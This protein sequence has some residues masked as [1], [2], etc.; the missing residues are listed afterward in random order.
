MAGGVPF[1]VLRG[2][3]ERHGWTLCRVRGLNHVFRKPGRPILV[4]PVHGGEVK[5]AYARKIE[6]ECEEED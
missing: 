2:L 6:K 4:V 1:A 5:A 3:L